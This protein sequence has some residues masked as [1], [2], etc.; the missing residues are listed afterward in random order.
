MCVKY[1]S[2]LIFN[3]DDLKRRAISPAQKSLNRLE[4]EQPFV[5]VYRD[6]KIAKAV[7]FTFGSTLKYFLLRERERA[8][9]RERRGE[10]R[11]T[12]RCGDI[13]VYR[14]PSISRTSH[15]FLFFFLHVT[16]EPADPR[17]DGGENRD[18]HYKPSDKGM[19]RR[20]RFA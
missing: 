18:E 3:R 2:A 9:G 14:S 5:V 20:G 12:S 10:S 6:E 11:V 8:S 4:T 7:L 13:S 17:D 16:A 15:S 19:T 1:T